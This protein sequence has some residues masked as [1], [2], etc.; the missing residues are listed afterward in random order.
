VL[1]LNV[2][3]PA[4]SFPLLTLAELK[5]APNL[6]VDPTDTSKDEELQMFIDIWL[7]SRPAGNH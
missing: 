5:L 1:D 4:D 7:C 2:L 3:G 6:P